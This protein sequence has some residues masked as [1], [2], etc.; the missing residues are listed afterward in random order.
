MA[1]QK[2]RA[3]ARVVIC[4]ALALETEGVSAHLTNLRREVHDRGTL[5]LRGLYRSFKTAWDVIVVEC[6]PGNVQVAVELERVI[7]EYDPIAAF[8]VGIAGGIKDV[9]IGDVLVAT[10]VYGYES[11][12][13]EEELLARPDVSASSYMLEQQARFEAKRVDWLRRIKGPRPKRK[14]RVLIGPLAAG[15]KVL[16]STGSS[17]YQFLR[18]NYSDAL[19]VDMESHGFLKAARA[20]EINAIVIRGISDLIDKKGVADAGGSQ[21]VAVRHAS[22]FTFQILSNLSPVIQRIGSGMNFITDFREKT[23]KILGKSEIAP[24]LRFAQGKD[25]LQIRQRGAVKKKVKVKNELEESRYKALKKRIKSYWDQY[26]D[27]FGELPTKSVDE[28]ARLKQVLNGIKEELCRDFREMIK[29]FEDAIDANLD[30]Y[31]LLYEVCESPPP[32]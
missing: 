16:K 2:E 20:N 28:K 7:E 32:L 31:R 26:N 23:L 14:P 1:D 22:A 19:A 11:G 6:G 12:A 30:E 5:Y 8:F 17:V 27:I 4:T 10:K 9:R 25:T 21:E 29:L 3:S 15:E 24:G 13:A 18:R